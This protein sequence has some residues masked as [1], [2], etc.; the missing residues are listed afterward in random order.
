MF[1]KLRD[2]IALEV[3]KQNVATLNATTGLGNFEMDDEDHN[4]W[5]DEIARGAYSLADA[6]MRVRKEF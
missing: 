1:M 5:L 3:L 2:K 6:M 4:D